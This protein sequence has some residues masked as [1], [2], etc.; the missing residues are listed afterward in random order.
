MLNMIKEIAKTFGKKQFKHE[1]QHTQ[2]NTLMSKLEK[3]TDDN[4]FVMEIKATCG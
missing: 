1:K 3:T 2:K 4:R